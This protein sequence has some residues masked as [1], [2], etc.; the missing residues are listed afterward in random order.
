ML[1]FAKDDGKKTYQCFVCG[2]KFK[3]G[4]DGHGFELFK[5]HIID[6]HEEGRD[7]VLCSLPRC[8]CPVRDQVLHYKFRHPNEVMP[9]K[10]QM[11]ALIW[12]DFSS[13]GK[14]KTRKPKFREGWYESSKMKKRFYYRSGWEETVFE[15]LD[16]HTE[17]FAFDAEPFKIPYLYN[18]LPHE[19]IPDLLVT[20]MD[21]HKEIWEVK[22]ANQTMLEQNHCKWKAAAEVCKSRG[23]KFIIQTEVGIGKLKKLVEQQNYKNDI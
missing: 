16:L 18:G 13:T 1:P 7:Y 20:F 15:C 9:K 10:G 4:P 6:E 11:R 21:Q 2:I 17:V 23:W 3:D 5:K 12:R 14:K 19:Y 22:P 8:H